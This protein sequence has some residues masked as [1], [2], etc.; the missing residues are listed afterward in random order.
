MDLPL[1]ALDVQELLD[2]CIDFRA[3][4]RYDLLACALV[5]RS[6]AAAAQSHLFREVLFNMDRYSSELLWW[7]L[8][9]TL[10]ASPHLIR[11]I[12][13]LFVNSDALTTP[14]FLEICNFPFTHLKD[15][16]IHQSNDVTLV[17]AMGMQQLFSLPS[18][19]R[20]GF[21]CYYIE[22]ASF[23]RIW[24][25]SAAGVRHLQ[26]CCDELST[27]P[28]VFTSTD[29][30]VP[31]I[32]LESLQLASGNVI[33]T[34]EG[35]GDWLMNA[36]CPFDLSSLRVLSIGWH[37]QILRWQRITPALQTLEAI[38]FRFDDTQIT[39]DTL[40]DLS[41]LPN[42][43]LLRMC[44]PF[45]EHHP[46]A[47]DTLATIG[48]ASRIRK[49]VLYESWLG[50]TACEALDIRI[51]GLP[52]RHLPVLEIEM[53]IVWGGL[54]AENLNEYFPR[55]SSRN[56]VQHVVENDPPFADFIKIS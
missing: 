16:Y 17:R 31:S 4:S 21:L 29:H 27:E 14:G 25:R 34:L 49:I 39:H 3:H 48:S 8:R 22:A 18:L 2:R 24:E 38:D 50:D 55:L 52:M 32:V 33:S 42:L 15:V 45:P 19:R 5:S 26:V 51:S 35:V 54:G 36:L 9:G 43:I 6:W 12:R 20:V 23:P 40:V 1:S 41:L 10:S 28:L 11:H 37:T 7:Q 46:R 30:D 47:L 44:I 13:L 56:P 53:R